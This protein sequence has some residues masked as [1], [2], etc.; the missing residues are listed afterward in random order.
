MKYLAIL[1]IA[2][3]AACGK[4]ETTTKTPELTVPKTPEVT[5]PKTP[6][7]ET[8]AVPSTESA[9]AA[10]DQAIADTKA[11]IEKKQTE[12]SALLGKIK[13]DPMKAATYQTEYDKLMKEIADLQTKLEGYQKQ[14]TGK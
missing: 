11:L 12:A 13:S 4:E 9:K 3:A 7:T 1:A 6:A 14:A 2:L 8:P 5:A 10:L